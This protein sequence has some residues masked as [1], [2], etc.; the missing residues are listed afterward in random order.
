MTFSGHDPDT[1]PTACVGITATCL[2]AGVAAGLAFPET[3]TIGCAVPALVT[4][5][6]FAILAWRWSRCVTPG[7]SGATAGDTALFPATAS[8]LNRVPGADDGEWIVSRFRIV[9]APVAGLCGGLF[10]F[11]VS[12]L[13][14]RAGWHEY[15][16]P[17]FRRP[18][19]AGVAVL[20]ALAC[21]I[22]GSYL[23]GAS[24]ESRYR[25]LRPT[26]AWLKFAAVVF[27][28]AAGA[29]LLNYGGFTGWDHRFSHLVL[30][31]T[32]MLGA[33]L[34]VNVV[35]ERFRPRQRPA[36]ER[37]VF[38]SRLLSILAEPGGI[39]ANIADTLNYQFGFNVS[40]SWCYRTIERA[41]IPYC[42][43]AVLLLYSLDCVV[44][45]DANQAGIRERFGKP[46]SDRI[47]APGLYLKLPRPFE[48]VRK[49]PVGTVMRTDIGF[50]ATRESDDHR[51]SHRQAVL[52]NAPHYHAETRFLVA[53]T[54]DDSASMRIISAAIPIF[55]SI[56]GT[57]AFSYAYN[58]R[59]PDVALQNL[60]SREVLLYL[61]SAD[62][63]GLL[64]RDRLAARDELERRIRVA[65][66]R[67]TP[68]LG[69]TICSVGL[70]DVHPPTAIAD[71]FQ[72]VGA[73]RERE[74]GLVLAASRYA[75][76][77]RATGAALGDRQRLEAQA[78]SFRKKRMSL[79]G[80]QRY[81]QYATVYEQAPAV[82]RHRMYLNV[83]EEES[84]ANANVIVAAGAREVIVV[85][86]KAQRRPDLLRDL[87]FGPDPRASQP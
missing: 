43:L 12:L 65:V 19:A 53:G 87:D 64:A 9:A 81:L 15:S 36:G 34:L 70:M 41:F 8:I 26:A 11:V 60:A 61:G 22:P 5:C 17:G 40:E 58:Y 47:M 83:L 69:V 54:Q 46:I 35:I 44:Q 63:H 57:E 3:R 37:P 14:L 27:A 31:V 7:P 18:A 39:A 75:A 62:Y 13:A 2:A 52:W 73:V 85:D 48:S 21:L 79:E 38:E 20:L 45:V 30:V 29:H 74:R 72:S 6:A 68:P 86:L 78:E 10:L 42:M 23:Y 84:S 56:D 16:A 66:A 25:W 32:A 82:F 50:V 77:Q 49:I 4:A 28:A 67:A 59:D 76:Q 71:A 55:Y 33:E 80:R 51:D 1:L 24:H